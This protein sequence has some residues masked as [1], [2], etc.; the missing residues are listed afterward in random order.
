M[1]SKRD[2]EKAWGK[3]KPIRGRNADAWRKD[4]GGNTIRKGSYG[5]A[6]KY[7]WELDHKKPQ[8][9]CGSDSAWNLQPLRWRGIDERATS[10][11]VGRRSSRK[12]APHRARV[13]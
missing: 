1:A 8:S 2:I 6:G 12:P 11:P 4:T 13:V 10:T 3:A 5:T 9:K 7:G